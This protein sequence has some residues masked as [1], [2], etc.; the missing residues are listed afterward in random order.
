MLKD[1]RINIG[2]PYYASIYSATGE[3][4]NSLNTRLC[5]ADVLNVGEYLFKEHYE[6]YLFTN[7]ERFFAN[8]ES[9]YC[10]L[11]LIQLKKHIQSARRLFPFTYTVEETFYLDNPAYKVVLDIEAD[12]FYHRYLHQEYHY[13]FF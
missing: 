2:F 1:Y 6:I 12:H 8:H 10:L 3:V 5:F 11:S 7:H 13:Q 9:N 4:Y